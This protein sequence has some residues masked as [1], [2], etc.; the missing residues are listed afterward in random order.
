MIIMFT[1]EQLILVGIGL[2]P[3]SIKKQRTKEGCALAVRAL[4]W[5]VQYATSQGWTIRVPL[6]ERLQHTIW[7]MITHQ[8]DNDHV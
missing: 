7:I 4:F 6:I 2:L 1:H 5:S 3:Y 8:R